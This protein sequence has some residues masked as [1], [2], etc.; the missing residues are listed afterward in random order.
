MSRMT[1]I[2]IFLLLWYNTE[3]GFFSQISV[4]ALIWSSSLGP[5]QFVI[6]PQIGCG[7]RYVIK[8]QQC[9]LQVAICLKWSLLVEGRKSAG[10]LR[11]CFIELFLMKIC[12]KLN[13]HG[14]INYWELAQR[15]WI[16]FPVL[17]QYIMNRFLPQNFPRV[18][19]L[20]DKTFIL[21][22]QESY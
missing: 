1:Q 5:S 22:L 7:K 20:F 17:A 3:S 10:I 21:N 16:P 12:F 13:F 4:Q 2:C 8:L 19:A 9:D 14:E 11:K 6:Q 15:P 18:H